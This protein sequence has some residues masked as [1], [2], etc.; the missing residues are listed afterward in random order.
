MCTNYVGQLQNVKCSSDGTIS[1]RRE[2]KEEK[3]HLKQQQL[4]ISPN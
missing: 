2:K 3:K 4:K 1:R